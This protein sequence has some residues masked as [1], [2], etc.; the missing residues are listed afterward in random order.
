MI[1]RPVI[2]FV[3]LFGVTAAAMVAAAQRR[4]PAGA[5][6]QGQA[7]SGTAVLAGTL[8][9]ATA[10]A[11]PVRHAVVRLAAASGG[12]AR[13]VGTDA[14]GRFVFTALPAG[15]YHLSATKAGYLPAAYGAMRP[16]RAGVPI[17][18][19]EGQRLDV[20][21]ALTRGAVI[22]GRI[23][24]AHGGP[25]PMVPVTAVG[26]RPS[27]A[28]PGPAARAM[29]DD[30]G[31]YRI[32][33]V[34][35]GDYVVAALPRLGAGQSAVTGDILGITAGERD[36]MRAQRGTAALV[37]G[38][39]PPRGRPV[40]YAP[41]FFPGTTR[42][43]DAAVLAVGIGEERGSIDFALR[44]EP[45]ARIGGTLLD[46]TGQPVTAASVS[47]HPRRTGQRAITDALVASRALVLPAAVVN[48][49]AFSISGVV[50]GDYTL[51]ARTGASGRGVA[52]VAAQPATLW[53]VTNIAIDGL[54]QTDLVLRLLPGATISGRI[55]VQLSSAIGL[56][57]VTQA[58]IRMVALDP[59][60][61][62]LAT[63]AAVVDAAGTFRFRSVVPG[64]YALDATF[65]ASP[66]WTM[67]S[68]TLQGRD[69]ADDTLDLRAGQDVSDLVLTFT[70]RP[71][72]IRG[73]LVDAANQAVTRYTIVVFTVNQAWWR[74]HARRIQS[75]RPATDGTFAI[76]GLPAGDYAIA[77]VDGIEPSELGDSSFLSQLLASAHRIALA[78]GE[79]KI[80]NL[81]VGS[82]GR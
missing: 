1:R 30:R 44:V 19:A 16:G 13:V 70:D 78:E 7:A 35:P 60:I 62:G 57:S 73:R 14:E 15:S 43:H 65:P 59:L 48:A 77:A 24:D 41:V 63:P 37:R 9:G 45:T 20:T 72:A 23:S 25:A 4:D 26:V 3:L 11:S 17:A 79:T 51:V 76:D 33:G 47:L 64:A 27:G 74:P 28:A 50:P 68:A 12:S 22:T 5:A 75:T 6:P 56:E 58:A 36:W 34:P 67:T 69:I 32:H 10:P 49:P 42:V 61:G 2:V 82:R 29:T 38:P 80:Q 40:T 81:R 66:R 54:D 52:P 53:S 31:I 46:D 39:L 55:V 71:S 8:E 21:L 18:I